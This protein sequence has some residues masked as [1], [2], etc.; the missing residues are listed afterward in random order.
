M[1]IED[2]KEIVRKFCGLFNTGN[3]PAILGTMAEDA[4]WW[5][6]GKSHLYDGAGIRT[7]SDME[8]SWQGLYSRLEGGLQLNIVAMTAEDNRVAAEVRSFGPT[9]VGTVYENDYHFLFCI[10]DGEIAEVREYGDMMH[11]VEIFG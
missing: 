8:K 3:I 1:S 6:N 11:A 2:N 10:R 7:K 4:T 5:V 9:T